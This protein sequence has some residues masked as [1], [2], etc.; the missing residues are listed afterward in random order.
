MN[1]NDQALLIRPNRE[2]VVTIKSELVDSYLVSFPHDKN[3]TTEIVAA[4]DL[5][6]LTSRGLQHA[7]DAAIAARMVA[8]LDAAEWEREETGS[9]SEPT[10]FLVG[11]YDILRGFA[12]HVEEVFE[13]KG[14]IEKKI[15]A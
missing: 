1:P 4:G 9:V 5:F 14:V 7:V 2:H 8:A 10:E 12:D 15:A 11:Q 13:S 3:R 6:P